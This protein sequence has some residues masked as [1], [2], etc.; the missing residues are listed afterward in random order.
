MDRDWVNRSACRGLDPT[1]FYPA[2]E[3]EADEAKAVCSVCPVQEDCLEHAIGNR[4]HNGVWGGATERE[5]QRII[6][7]RRRLRAMGA[8][9]DG[10]GVEVL[11]VGAR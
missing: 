7:R 1:I 9:T 4:E 8:P 5:R 6:R 11:G 2:T 10:V 3:E